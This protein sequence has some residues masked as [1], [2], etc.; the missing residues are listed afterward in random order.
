MIAN[1]SRF[2]QVYDKLLFFLKF[3]RSPRQIGSI[4][5]SSS[6]LSRMMLEPIQWEDGKVIVELGAGT[7]VFT[8][9]IQQRRSKESCFVLFEKDE[10]LRQRL[11]EQLNDVSCFPDASELSEVL[12]SEGVQEADYIVSGLP[13]A[14]FSLEQRETIMTQVHSSLKQDGL[15]ITFQYSLQMKESLQR[16]FSKVKIKL[17]VG[18]LPPAFVYVCQK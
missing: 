15:F 10:Y 3:I 9:A 8:R 4:T 16:K 12:A 1:S 7:G 6:A 13:F 2:L 18:N 5:P 14:N 11:C 17:V